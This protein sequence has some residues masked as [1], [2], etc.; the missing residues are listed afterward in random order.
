M[1]VGIRLP[2]P[3][4]RR[5]SGLEQVK[6]G[7][8]GGSFIG[9]ARSRRTGGGPVLA[10]QR[11]PG[12]M[13]PSCHTIGLRPPPGAVLIAG[14]LDG[15]LSLDMNRRTLKSRPGRRPGPFRAPVT[16]AQ[17]ARALIEKILDHLRLRLP[18][19]RRTVSR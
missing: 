7:S 8:P 12:S 15:A 6:V 10:Q 17:I 9:S 13:S 18:Q 1:R 14:R 19:A 3:Y 5:L 16:Q 11:L 2:R 4:R